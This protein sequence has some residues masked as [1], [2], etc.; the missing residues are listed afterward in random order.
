MS[1]AL[2]DFTLIIFHFQN[3]KRDVALQLLSKEQ[4]FH[5]QTCA[6]YSTISIIYIETV[7]HSNTLEIYMYQLHFNYIP[8]VPF[9]TFNRFEVVFD[10][11]NKHT[12]NTVSKMVIK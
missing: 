4:Y 2:H 7:N 8:M 5:T 11:V 3:M 12:R 10:E 1:R 9:V 6:L